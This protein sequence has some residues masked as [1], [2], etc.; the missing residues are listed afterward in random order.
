MRDSTTLRRALLRATRVASA[1]SVAATPS[2]YRATISSAGGA[3]PPASSKSAAA[4]RR[5][6]RATSSQRL[7]RRAALTALSAASRYRS[8][9]E[10]D[11]RDRQRRG[12]RAPPEL[13]WRPRNP[14]EIEPAASLAGPGLPF[15][16][17]LALR[18]EDLDRRL[19]QVDQP[20]V[21]VPD[22]DPVTTVRAEPRAVRGRI[23]QPAAVR[24]GDGRDGRRLSGLGRERRDRRRSLDAL[25]GASHTQKTPKERD[26]DHLGSWRR[27]RVRVDSRRRPRRTTTV[28]S[29]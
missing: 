23:E 9:D 28:G 18:L 12:R 22:D 29:P 7:A 20:A 17:E 11:G 10:S 4:W 5:R 15:D 3:L 13:G 2:R 6:I 21:R 26:P 8:L 14:R 25:V 27:P 19:G 16:L 24:A 1:R